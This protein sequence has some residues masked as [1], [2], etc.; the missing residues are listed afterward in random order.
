MT[1]GRGLG[2]AGRGASEGA[3]RVLVRGG[4]ASLGW[5]V[6]A[7]G[8]SLGGGAAAGRGWL[9]ALA[10]FVLP[11][12]LIWLA[13]WSALALARLRAEAAELRAALARLQAPPPVRE[14]GNGDAPAFPGPAE[15]GPGERVPAERDPAGTRSA[16][17]GPAPARAFA[18]ARRG[19]A[20]PAPPAIGGAGPGMPGR[21]GR[22]DEAQGGLA[23]GPPPPPELTPAELFLALNFPDGPDDREAIRC[24][25]LALGDPG[26]ARLIRA[27]QDVVTLLAGQG[28]YM[29]DLAPPEADPRAWRSLAEGVRGAPIAALAGAG[30]TAALAVV[31]GLL[32]RDEVFRDAAH[33]FLRQFD[34]L[35]SRHAADDEDGMLTALGGTRSGRAFL[36]L[37]EATGIIVPARG[38][39]AGEAGLLQPA[40][41]ARDGAGAA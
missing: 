14:D 11:L 6:L 24:L 12:A 32:R 31:R 4:L 8:L 40:L 10:A 33:H 16:S 37:A 27:A 25:R 29:D 3:R 1:P 23:L 26:L 9:V 7:A 17:P 2:R 13:V 28:I 21:P 35:L 5:I 18:P 36:L 39:D 20:F 41:I 38:A 15:A 22:G 19:S 34:R 30:D